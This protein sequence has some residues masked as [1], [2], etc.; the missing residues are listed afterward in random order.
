MQLA[1][2]FTRV[3]DSLVAVLHFASRVR[4][5]VGIARCSFLFTT[6]Y[7]SRSPT[8]AHLSVARSSLQPALFDMLLQGRQNVRDR[9]TVSAGQNELAVRICTFVKSDTPTSIR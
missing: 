5:S 2:H 9:E 7:A 8:A 4:L 1:A 6:S 3:L